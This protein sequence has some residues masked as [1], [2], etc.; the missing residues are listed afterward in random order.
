MPD[1]ALQSQA[2]QVAAPV[3]DDGLRAALEMLAQNILTRRKAK[4]GKTP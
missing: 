3:Q 4:E 1:P 2:R